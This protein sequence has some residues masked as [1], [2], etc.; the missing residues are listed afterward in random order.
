VARALAAKVEQ[1]VCDVD[2]AKR[3]AEMILHDNPMAIFNLND[4]ENGTVLPTRRRLEPRFLITH[5]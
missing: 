1:Q 5:T 3:L 4:S 2:Y